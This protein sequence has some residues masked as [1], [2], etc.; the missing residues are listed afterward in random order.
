MP[1]RDGAPV[2]SHRKTPLQRP[3]DRRLPVRSRIHPTTDLLDNGSPPANCDLRI[4]PAMASQWSPCSQGGEIVRMDARRR[5]I[6]PCFDAVRE[7]RAPVRPRLCSGP[8][9]SASASASVR[10]P[11]R[12]ASERGRPPRSLGARARSDG[13]TP[14]PHNSEDPLTPCLDIHH[15]NRTS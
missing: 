4:P 3:A 12:R 8:H 11:R 14:A 7:S 15:E 2:P 9:A 6:H 1:R 5:P 10:S 13:G